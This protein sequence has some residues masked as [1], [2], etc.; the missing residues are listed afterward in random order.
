VTAGLGLIG[1]IRISVSDRERAQRF[2]GPTLARLGF[3]LADENEDRVC[4]RLERDG[5]RLSFLLSEA[6]PE[7]RGDRFELGALGLHHLA[8]QAESRRQVDDFHQFL[9]DSGATVQGPPAFYDYSPGYYAVYFRDP[10]NLKF[11]L[12][13][14]PD[15]GAVGRPGTS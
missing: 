3:S 12:A 14:V 5:Q 13:H 1:H 15:A 4:Y 9:V 2:W 10:D 6:P 11:E 8:F 7:C